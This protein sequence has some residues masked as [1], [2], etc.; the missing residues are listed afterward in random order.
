MILSQE[1]S[2]AIKHTTPVLSTMASPSKSKSTK[3]FA[4]PKNPS[5]M[6][7]KRSP[8]KKEEIEKLAQEQSERQ[9]EMDLSSWGF[10]GSIGTCDQVPVLYSISKEE[11]IKAM[12]RDDC[13]INKWLDTFLRVAPR[14]GLAVTKDLYIFPFVLPMASHGCKTEREEKKSKLDEVRNF[15]TGW[16]QFIEQEEWNESFKSVAMIIKL[17][18]CTGTN[19]EGEKFFA[20]HFIVLHIHFESHT[21]TFYDSISDFEHPGNPSFNL[22]AWDKSLILSYA[23]M[24]MCKSGESS[25]GQVWVTED[26]ELRGKRLPLGKKVN[27]V[28]TRVFVKN[29]SSLYNSKVPVSYGCG[30]NCCMEVLGLLNPDFKNRPA[31]ED[32]QRH[33][34]YV[35]SLIIQFMIN[36]GCQLNST[37]GVSEEIH[38]IRLDLCSRLMK[39]DFG[40]SFK[41][42]F[43]NVCKSYNGWPASLTCTGC[44]EALYCVD[45][46]SIVVRCCCG[47]CMHAECYLK[48]L[49]ELGEDQ[50]KVP[51]CTEIRCV[52]SHQHYSDGVLFINCQ[53]ECVDACKTRDV[54]ELKSFLLNNIVDSNKYKE[55]TVGHWVPW[56]Y[57]KSQEAKTLFEYTHSLCKSKR[58]S[59]STPFGSPTKRQR[60]KKTGG[61][62]FTLTSCGM[63]PIAAQGLQPT[64]DVGE[65]SVIPFGQSAL[66]PSQS[67]KLLEVSPNKSLKGSKSIPKGG[68]TAVVPFG[69]LN[70]LPL[71]SMELFKEAKPPATRMPA[72]LAQFD[73]RN[74][75][76]ACLQDD[77]NS[78]YF[79]DCLIGKRT[80]RVETNPYT[81]V[82]PDGLNKLLQSVFFPTNAGHFINCPRCNLTFD[83]IPAFEHHFALTKL[84]GRCTPSHI[85]SRGIIGPSIIF[86]PNF[87][88][89]FIQKLAS[90]SSTLQL[91]VDDYQMASK[92][93]VLNVHDPGADQRATKEK[94]DMVLVSEGKLGVSDFFQ[95][96][97][98]RLQS[99]LDSGKE[100]PPCFGLSPFLAYMP[101]VSIWE[102]LL[103]GCVDPSVNSSLNKLRQQLIS[104]V[105]K[106]NATPSAK[107]SSA[108]DLISTPMQASF[109]K[110]STQVPIQNPKVYAQTLPS[111]WQYDKESQVLLGKF[112][113]DAVGQDER[114][115]AAILGFNDVAT[116]TEG[117]IQPALP[118]CAKELINK[119]LYGYDFPAIVFVSKVEGCQIVTTEETKKI[120]ATSTDYVRYLNKRAALIEN[121]G[122][123]V[124]AMQLPMNE[125]GLRLTNT[126]RHIH[127]AKEAMYLVDIDLSCG[128][129][130]QKKF[131]DGLGSVMSKMLPSKDW[132]L[133]NLVRSFCPVFCCFN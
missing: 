80:I 54:G 77:T 132:C 100:T 31:W 106:G 58:N 52:L 63:L 43:E 65:K 51:G 6:V 29:G 125:A 53:R 93:P 108:P 11:V 110:L 14:L 62:P 88:L 103:T 105:G 91:R 101:Y 124:K 128:E 114:N 130:M 78:I 3:D 57:L 95:N 9:R 113:G 123:L 126:V 61:E 104:K 70:S 121:A 92:L 46:E 60:T 122:S 37:L 85:S 87:V 129:E 69:K 30:E 19:K 38:R 22:P 73:I 90:A 44:T 10:V 76:V 35:I 32:I 5:S 94:E 102:S 49:N 81:E 116:V 16:S 59:E 17:D 86:I 26:E 34:A 56:E 133:T 18:A 68:Q 118:G 127:V 84:L 107:N 41:E 98:D 25:D 115:L 120:F 72:K 45:G 39:V 36:A 82:D 96:A 23:Y 28:K 97:I 21:A 48:F 47:H 12:K 7:S 4:K 83:N 89:T 24:H 27:K 109:A 2:I 13:M 55:K 119:F 50:T 99:I 117:L 79:V 15:F 75:D 111:N 64:P 20:E 8:L 131:K 1:T 74:S 112:N 67:N 42:I 33:R 66:V 40:Q 71:E